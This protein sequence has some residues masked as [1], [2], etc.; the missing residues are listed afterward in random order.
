MPDPFRTGPHGLLARLGGETMTVEAWG[1]DALR[2][3]ATPNARFDDALPSGLLPGLTP[4]PAEVA[5]EGDAATIRNG[6]CRATVRREAGGLR[7]TLALSFEDAETGAAL[8][9]EEMGHILYPTARHWLAEAG[10]L[11][12]LEA[13]FASH[14][15]E[16]FWG[17]G[18]HQHGRL[19]Q[20]GCVVGLR[21]MNTQVSIPFLVSSRGYGVIWNLAATGQVELAANH[22][23]WV[24]EAT[25]QMD[26]VVI[27][28]ATPAGILARYGEL[29]GR[30]PALPPW[31]SGFWQCKLRYETQAE[32]LA[33]AREHRDRGLPIACIVIDFFNWTRG[34]EWRFEPAAF[35][36]P[37][38]M[39]A[40]L[41]GMGI[42]PMVSVWPTVNENAETF[43]AMRDAGYLVATRRGVGA[44]MVFFDAG[45]DD[46]AP[47]HYYDA[48]NPEALAFHWGRVRAGYAD[49]GFRSF[50]LDANEPEVYPAHHDNMRLH[51]GEY[52]AVGGAFPR[53]HQEGYAEGLS[54]AG[55]DGGLLLSRSA[56]IGTQRLP[57]VVWSGDVKSTFADLARQVRAG[58]NMAMSGIAWW[59]T[60]IGGFKGG[61]VRDPAFHELLIRWFQYGAFC[62]I[63]RLHGFRQDGEGDP[64]LGREFLFGGAANEVW[65]FGEDVLAH[66]RAIMA[67]REALRAY[68]HRAADRASAEG[69][70]P[71][72][73]LLVDFPDDADAVAVDDAFLFGGDLLVAPVLEPGATTRRVYLPADATWRDAWTGEA[74]EA[75]AWHE[76]DAPLE[77]IP[78]FLRDGAARPW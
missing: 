73:P 3:R 41:R 37:A 68:V 38:A 13:R 77:R 62:P 22:T 35:P 17:L 12:R 53:L 47:L 25:S 51:A 42:E 1:R 28:G 2:V 10:P 8:L 16:R 67:L 54:D 61:D 50:W 32:V 19:D 18:Q 5:V 20:K 57:V 76:V 60:D 39:V 7:P 14:D 31:A 26:Y 49:H 65:A 27:A 30:P 9:R 15:G 48:T 33:V 75:G 24:A 6:R 72:R 63:F 43:P 56:W 34:G 71:M 40:A 66:L 58:L 29:T 36:D 46:L 55:L 11:H 44:Q 52:R 4:V 21:Q 45:G 23:K 70:P 69:L 74:A 78:V 64:R 59:T